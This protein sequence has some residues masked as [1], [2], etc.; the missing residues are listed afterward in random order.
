MAMSCRCAPISTP[1]PPVSRA[2]PILRLVSDG[3]TGWWK[4]K[5]SCWLSRSIVG[6]GLVP[7]RTDKKNQNDKMLYTS[8]S[9]FCRV[10]LNP[11][12][13]LQNIT[14][15]AVFEA[16]KFS[17]EKVLKIVNKDSGILQHFISS[18]SRQNSLFLLWHF[19]NYFT[20]HSKYWGGNV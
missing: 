12:T 11:H 16:D 6:I 17:A 1:P 20:N 10:G 9:E 7:F 5:F 4:N 3:E 13:E 8:C 18:L 19:A 2:T 14:W 15:S